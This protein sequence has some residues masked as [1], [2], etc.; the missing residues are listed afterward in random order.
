MKEYKSLT[1]LI[2]EMEP[3]EIFYKRI[4][5]EYPEAHLD[6]AHT[7]EEIE[8][9][10]PEASSHAAAGFTY[11]PGNALD[12]T[13]L[14]SDEDTI[15]FRHNRYSPAF[16]H[17]H[18]FFEMIYVLRGTCENIFTSHTISMQAGDICIVAP[19]II[20]ALSAFSDDCVIYNF[21][22]KS[23]TF[24]AVFLNSLPKYGTLHDFFS[25][26]LYSPGSQFYLYFKSGKDP[27]A[28]KF[29]QKNPEGIPG[30]KTVQSF[31][32]KR[33]A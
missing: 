30:A 10:C 8:K 23:Q 20:H 12:E 27:T 21:L 19:S 29:I 3:D 24:E 1:E 22:I 2:P 16:L 26:A 7:V 11:H 6:Q 17:S 13:I 15:I 31:Y 28:C 33:S 32:D 18:T 5:L 14:P 9:L 4:F 25:R